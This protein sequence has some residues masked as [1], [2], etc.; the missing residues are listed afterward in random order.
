[1][2]FVDR[3]NATGFLGKE[4]L[5]WL[6]YKSDAQEGL[7]TVGPEA[8]SAEVWMTDRIVLSGAG[9]GAERVAV[10]TEDPTL[11]LEARTAL[12]QGKKVEQARLRIISGQRE[13]SAT[14]KGE[15]LAVSSIKIPAL[16]TKEE[17]DKLRERFMLLDQIDEMLEFLFKSFAELRW[18]TEKWG[19][20]REAMKVWIAA[21]PSGDR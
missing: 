13:W 6:W 21:G 16:L 1:M 20:E 11:S 8:L 12:A 9:Q 14:I 19:A 10:R 7:M 3:L 18:D 4:F 2:D 17:D 15:T 5:T